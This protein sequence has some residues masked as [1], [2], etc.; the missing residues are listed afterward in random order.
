MLRRKLVLNHGPLVLLLLLTAVAAI[1]LLQGVLRDLKHVEEQA[2]GIIERV[3]ELNIDIS[4]AEVNLYRLRLGQTGTSLELTN[5]VA[6]LR[7]N[8]DDIS[9][10]WVSDEPRCAELFVTVRGELPAFER[11][12]AALAAAPDIESAQAHVEPALSAALALQRATLPMSRCI[13]DHAH[14]EQT[15][16]VNHFRWLVLGLS[17]VF[18]LLINV[19]VIVL[20]RLGAIVIRPV[21]KLILATRQLETEHFDY[22]VQ[23]EQKDEFDD[24]ARA[25]NALAGQLQANERRRV[26]TL[27]QAGVTMSHELN[28]ATAI[29]E[30]QLT[31]LSRQN[32]GNG[33]L[34][35][36]LREI[37]QSLRRVTRTVRSL[38]NVRRIVLTD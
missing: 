19:A 15:A 1:G 32:P 34:E 33:P 23:L 27:T 26:E 31:K 17:I 37:H 2:W 6:S 3:N 9:A 5:A 22:R 14:R 13:L 8:V 24:L 20:L 21:D 30:L 35:Q 11:E 28:N 4:S 38:G 10:N 18:L 29:I 16:L 36:C 7:R 25:S 12:V